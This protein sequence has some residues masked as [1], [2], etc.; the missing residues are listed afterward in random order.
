MFPRGNFHRSRKT[1]VPDEPTPTPPPISEDQRERIEAAKKS[2]SEWFRSRPGAMPQE[3]APKTTSENIADWLERRTAAIRAGQKPHFRQR[4][5][6]AIDD[7]KR[8][9]PLTQHDVPSLSEV[10]H[11]WLGLVGAMFAKIEAA[12]SDEEI[13]ALSRWYVREKRGELRVDVFGATDAALEV[14]GWA[15]D[16][17]ARVC[18]RCSAVATR[19]A[20]LVTLCARCAAKEGYR[21]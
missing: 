14:I 11:G 13:A 19:R 7:R 15:E 1:I 18:M 3:Q 21:E 20:S 6:S 5:Y 10:P 4:T 8:L 16:E 9:F 2:V 12:L 17:S